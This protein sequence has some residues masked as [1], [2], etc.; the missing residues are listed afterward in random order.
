MGL[1]TLG[2]VCK[3]GKFCKLLNIGKVMNME[4]GDEHW[5]RVMNIEVKFEV[6]CQ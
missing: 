1:V 4:Q 2:L 6:D 3:V 5:S